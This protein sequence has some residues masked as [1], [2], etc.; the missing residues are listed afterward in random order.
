M[1]TIIT[2]VKMAFPVLA[3]F[4]L[5]QCKA[6]ANASNRNEKTFIVGFIKPQTAP[7]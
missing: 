7:E 3:V 4:A 2:T 1:K 6:P 5:T